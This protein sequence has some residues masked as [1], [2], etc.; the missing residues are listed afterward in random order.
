MKRLALNQEV[1]KSRLNIIE[2]SRESLSRF[3][4]LKK[5]EFE[6]NPDNFRITFFDLQRALEAMIDIGSHILSRFPGA[7]PT[8][9]KEIALLLEKYKI[10]PLD[11]AKRKLLK[12]FGYRNRMV[13]FYYEI[14]PGELYQI[15]QKDSEDLEKFCYYINQL[16]VN[17]KRYGL[18]IA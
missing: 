2:K 7:R 14:T 13:H 4:T 12:M 10:L 5:E 11:F 9:Y 17:P 1:I 16:L 8:S 3:Q 18:E 6:S 15:I